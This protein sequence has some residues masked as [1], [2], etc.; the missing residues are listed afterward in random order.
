M[1]YSSKHFS[2]RII[3]LSSTRF[4]SSFSTH[5]NK[6][7]GTLLPLCCV[8]L[9]L[10]LNVDFAMWFFDFPSLV[11]RCGCFLNNHLIIFCSIVVSEINP[12]VLPLGFEAVRWIPS[13]CRISIPI[14]FCGRLLTTRILFGCLGCWSICIF[15]FCVKSDMLVSGYLAVNLFAFDSC[16]ND[17]GYLV[18]AIQSI[19]DV[20]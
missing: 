17:L 7:S 1:K 19:S 2:R 8:G 20:L 12:T 14:T 15:V 10:S 6:C 11:H 13:L 4:S 3:C 5:S 18:L 16:I 9:K